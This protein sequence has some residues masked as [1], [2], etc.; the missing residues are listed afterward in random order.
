[1]TTQISVLRAALLA[2]V[3]AAPA[4]A[5]QPASKPTPPDQ[6]AP[7]LVP[8]RPD[9]PSADVGKR[10]ANVAPP[11]MGVAE[12]ELPKLKVPKGFKVE[13]YAHGIGNARTLRIG[14]KG[15]VLWV[16]VPD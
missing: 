16:P 10:L 12:N 7:T 8:G 5:Q 13:V 11:P 15:T 1:M 4:F 14:D 3:L 2:G 6:P 9:I